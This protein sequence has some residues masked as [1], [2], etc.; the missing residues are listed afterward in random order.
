MR[1]PA[2]ISR[3]MYLRLWTATAIWISASVEAEMALFKSRVA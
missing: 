2:L 3:I 1:N